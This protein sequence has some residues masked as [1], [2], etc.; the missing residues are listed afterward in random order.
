[1]VQAL[2]NR[3]DVMCV[4]RGNDALSLRTLLIGFNLN[5]LLCAKN[6]DA[7]KGKTLYG[8][9]FMDIVVEPGR[10]SCMR[11][12]KLS[13][14]SKAWLPLATSADALVVCA[15]I[16]DVIKATACDARKCERCHHHTGP[17]ETA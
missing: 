12:V 14:S 7:A 10:G 2:E 13:P 5:L 3:G 11:S 15:G 16:G 8:F 9:D 6:T 4:E 1:M 17:D